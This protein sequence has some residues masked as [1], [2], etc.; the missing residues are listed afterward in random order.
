VVVTF[1][2]P[3]QILSSASANAFELCGASQGS[4]RYA[5]ARVIGNRVTLGSD[6]QPVTRVRYAWADYP[7]VNLYDQDL[8]PAPVFELPVQ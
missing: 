6:G 4:C 8:L 1:T 2:K 7:I 3:L 5:D